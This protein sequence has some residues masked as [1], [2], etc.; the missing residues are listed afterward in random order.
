MKESTKTSSIPICGE[1]LLSSKGEDKQ[2]KNITRSM[3][4]FWFGTGGKIFSK[5]VKQKRILIQGIVA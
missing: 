4:Q 5:Y 3:Y 2:V 1:C